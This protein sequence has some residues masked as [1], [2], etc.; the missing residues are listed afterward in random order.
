MFRVFVPQSDKTPMG[1]TAQRSLPA[2]GLA[3]W[4]AGAHGMKWTEAG[5]DDR[6]GTIYGWK[7]SSQTAA[8]RRMAFDPELDDV[9]PAVA[10]TDLEGREW[11]AWRYAILWPKG[12]MPR[13]DQ[14]AHRYP[15]LGRERLS[16]TLAGREWLIPSQNDLPCTLMH[17]RDGRAVP[18]LQDE[19]KP[20]GRLADAELARVQ[21]NER[22]EA[23]NSDEPREFVTWNDA[24]RL[25]LASLRVNYRVSPEVSDA[26][27]LV[28]TANVMDGYYRACGFVDAAILAKSEGR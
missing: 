27:R 22:L 3:D 17:T 11:P 20:Y 9:F 10:T 5:L 4:A 12:W 25:V 6:S 14:L 28:T 2:V 13:P 7:T 16:C 23:E 21:R 8:E 15:L 19:F 26:M 18:T 1:A 24:V